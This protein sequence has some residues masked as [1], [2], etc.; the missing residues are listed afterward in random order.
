MRTRNTPGGKEVALI[1]GP[2]ASGKSDLAV[3]LALALKA[4]GRDTVV[5][6]ADSAQV[7]RDLRV[8]SAR[9][10]EA[11]MRGV[12][13]RLFGAWDGAE[14]CS[15]ADW[16]AAARREIENAHLAG[17]VP[18]LVGGTGLYLRTLL[19]GIAPVPAIDADVR[20]AVRALPVADAYAAL[21]NEDAEA[22]ARLSPNDRARVTRALEVVRSSGR[23]LGEWQRERVGGIGHGIA[24]HPVVLLP[25]RGWIYE[26]CDRRFAAMLDKGAIAEVE[27]LLDRSLPASLPIMRAIGVRE[28]SAMLRGEISRDEALALGQQAT[29][30][31]AKRQYT[32]FRRQPPQEW[33]RVEAED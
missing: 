8:L 25:D 2:T 13:H 1:A 21:R 28:I 30:Q 24:L 4:R 12:E 27:A 11:E 23:P 32:W 22:A 7:Y 3:D 6:N 33:A 20:E 17:A 19:D 14:A 16:A 15:A 31:Y 29:R 26:R 18:I 10:A 9:P 5:I